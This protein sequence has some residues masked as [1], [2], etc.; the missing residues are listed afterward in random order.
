MHAEHGCVVA[1]VDDAC[2]E[3]QKKAKPASVMSISKAFG[4]HRIIQQAC[5]RFQF[6]SVTPDAIISERSL[7]E[8]RVESSQ[9]I[10]NTA[11]PGDNR[12]AH[13]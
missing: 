13:Q 9:D 10:L 2:H 3:S 8:C 5:S 11:T 1:I 6:R 4:E 12:S 7:G